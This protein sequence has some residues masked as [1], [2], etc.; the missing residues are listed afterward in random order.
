M[1]AVIGLILLWNGAV[2]WA[3]PI[4]FEDVTNGSGLGARTETWGVNWGDFNGDGWP[5][6]FIQGHRDFPRIYRNNGNGTFTDIAYRLD[7][8]GDWL[9]FTFNDTH[10]SALADMD[11]DGDDDIYLSQNGVGFESQLL[12][13]SQ[14]NGA[15]SLDNISA[16][17]GIDYTNLNGSGEVMGVLAD[18]NNDGETDIVSHTYGNGGVVMLQ[19]SLQFTQRPEL[20]CRGLT[21]WGQLA[22]VNND[23]TLDYV[24]GR[25]GLL[26]DGVVD[27]SNGQDIDTLLEPVNLVTDV[28]SGDFNGDLLTDLIY[29]RGAIRPT[30]AAFT[31]AQGVDAWFSH[32]TGKGITFESNG[33]V[34]FTLQ[35][36]W[37]GLY[38]DQEVVT[39]DPAT[40]ATPQVIRSLTISHDGTR[41]T[42]EHTTRPPAY[43]RIRSSTAITNLD[44]FGLVNADQPQFNHHLINNGPNL[45]RRYNTGISATMACVSGVAADFDNDM[46]LDVYLACRHGVENLANLYFDNRGDGTFDLVAGHGGEGPVGVGLE[47]GVADSVIAADYNADGFVDLMVTNGLLNAPLNQ[48][49]P[50]L[51]L[52]NAG[53]S[54]QWLQLDLQG[55]AS[56]PNGIGA[57]VFVTSG[58]ITQVREQ[59]G[60]Y[61]RWSQNHQRVHF[62]LGSNTQADIRIEW[63]S[64]QIDTHTGV[65]ADQI[66]VATENGTLQPRTLGPEISPTLSSTDTCDPPVYNASFGA[67]VL[68]WQECGSTIWHVRVR[69]GLDLTND[70]QTLTVSGDI[71]GMPKLGRVFGLDLTAQ[72]TLITTPTQ[73]DFTL[74]TSGTAGVSK[75]LV[76]DTAN[77]SSACLRFTGNDIRTVVIGSQ[78]IAWDNPSLSLTDLAHCEFDTDNDGLSDS[79]EAQLGT[80]PLV[81]DTD[82]G[83]VN[84]GDEVAN[85]T[86]PLDPSDDTSPSASTC[87]DPLVDPASDAG[88]FLWRECP[89]AGSNDAWQLLVSGGGLAWDQYVG[90]F[91]GNEIIT[92]SGSSLEGSDTLDSQPGD[93]VVDFTL[94]VGG[95][96]I[97]AATLDIPVQ[98]QTCLQ[99]T[100]NPAGMVVHVGSN[101]NQVT[102]P[103]NLQDLSPC[104]LDEN[105]NQPTWDPQQDPGLYLWKNC[106][107]PSNTEWIV[108][109]VGGGR[110]WDEYTGSIVSN[111]PVT[112]TTFSLEGADTFI[113]NP[114]QIDFSLFVGG[115][116]EDGF[117]ITIP[118]GADT[119]FEAG[120]IPTGIY[121]GGNAAQMPNRFNLEDL[122]PCL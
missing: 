87:G 19:S 46:D 31:D 20:L 100:N 30:H 54:N 25:L 110:A 106:N 103:F 48:G 70:Y 90:T 78:G 91:V 22:D 8:Q 5:D 112:T 99:V 37:M 6:I 95:N 121:A 40:A 14:I 60:G 67:A 50:E 10:G 1:R 105:C 111:Q 26:P 43:A 97:D 55:V 113:A 109:V 56:N 88:L 83:T 29:T 120:T 2:V 118:P 75:E 17:A 72:D 73:V 49:G 69:S 114:Q 44:T 35:G 93:S 47:F 13:S 79:T 59:N 58:G 117:T 108:R 94:A 27:L 63:P 53:N 76:I 80:N 21:Y 119:C 9:G 41:W 82:M 16:A 104:G 98:S 34:T 42:V 64:G 65:A 102:P 115:N 96:G 122:G 101:R 36:D 84:D 3:S 32:Q 116:G 62:G 89:T 92:A 66:Y 85:G 38:D 86:D 77:A 81:A 33:Q 74:Q 12:M 28:I 7:P 52:R 107:N 61:H 51:L 4:Q 15:T 18:I 23:G 71:T 24:C 39:L 45:A 68:I 11:G 57:K